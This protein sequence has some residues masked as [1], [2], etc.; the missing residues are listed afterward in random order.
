MA[1]YKARQRFFYKG[2]LVKPGEELD[3][4]SAEAA[5]FMYLG[6]IAAPPEQGKPK[7]TPRRQKNA[8]FTD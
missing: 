7:R 6:Y 8:R 2:F 4:N 1:T 5:R 3:L